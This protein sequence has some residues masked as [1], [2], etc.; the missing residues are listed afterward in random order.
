M[1][2]P[3]QAALFLSPSPQHYH[4]KLRVRLRTRASLIAACCKLCH[5]VFGA[6]RSTGFVGQSFSQLSGANRRLNTTSELLFLLG[7]VS[8]AE[9]RGPLNSPTAVQKGGFH[10]DT[11][12]G[13]KLA[14]PGSHVPWTF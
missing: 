1:P 2:G 4:M 8:P 14:G 9:R 10:G 11:G 6:G 13:R 3:L 12:Q 5:V 7:C